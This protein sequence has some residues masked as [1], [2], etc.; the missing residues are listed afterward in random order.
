ML[1]E[2]SEDL[3]T[4][5]MLAEIQRLAL[6]GDD[7]H[8][9]CRAAVAFLA[10]KLEAG[11]IVVHSVGPEGRISVL[12]ACGG[13]AQGNP[14][15]GTAFEIAADDTVYA[16]LLIGRTD[17]CESERVC[18]SVAAGLLAAAFVRLEGVSQPAQLLG[19][20]VDLAHGRVPPSVELVHRVRNI[21]SV[22][23]V[24]IRRTA[25]RA[26]AVEDYAAQLDGRI[27]A[28]ARVQTALVTSQEHSTDLGTMIDDEM[29]AHSIK[30]GRIRTQGPRI[31][32][33]AKAAETLGLTVHELTENAIKFGALSAKNGRI[34][35]SWWIDESS[36]PRQLRLEWIETGVPVLSSAPRIRGFG[37]E[38]IERTLPYE[39][40]A[41]THV[42]FLPGGFRCALTIPLSDRMISPDSAA[43]R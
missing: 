9:T 2:R 32:L 13:E 15:N 25:E 26:G 23:R 12:A 7:L 38:L 42:D 3:S 8:A 22:I 10:A 30:E 1:T 11:E 20:A 31:P 28:L 33:Q 21:L 6:H 29:L 43:V 27:S 34:D 16:T 14:A 17:L 35:V 18:A 39:L 37:H 4:L 36:H 5:K 41:K 19:G 24:I 40:S